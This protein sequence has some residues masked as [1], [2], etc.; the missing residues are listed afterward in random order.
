MAWW[1]EMCPRCPWQLVSTDEAPDT[2]TVY[3]SNER[4]SSPVHISSPSSPCFRTLI[5]CA[6]LC[7]HE[8]CKEDCR[9]E[10]NEER[11]T[12]EMLNWKLWQLCRWYF[13][14]G[15]EFTSNAPMNYLVM[16]QFQASINLC[17]WCR[18][19]NCVKQF[20][21]AWSEHG[22]CRTQI[23]SKVFR[24]SF[25]F[26]RFRNLNCFHFKVLAEGKRT[27][28]PLNY[29]LRSQQSI[30]TQILI[31]GPFFLSNHL[32]SEPGEVIDCN[33]WHVYKSFALSAKS[34]ESFHTPLV[35]RLV[36]P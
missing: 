21:V 11:K 8:K 27:C 7:Y 16:K 24:S 3:D 20:S 13:S 29:A 18:F 32:K 14:L 19:I 28:V 36:R 2:P 1:P 35:L 5:G 17:S 4:L 33:L 30:R 22:W 9:S 6:S 34:D 26:L 15:E 12:C 10:E 31:S 23:N 25:T